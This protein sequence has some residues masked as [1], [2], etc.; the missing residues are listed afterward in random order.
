MARVAVPEKCRLITYHIHRHCFSASV[1]EHTLEQIVL[2]ILSAQGSRC[3][4]SSISLPVN[5]SRF[6]LLLQGM[7]LESLQYG[8]RRARP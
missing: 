3:L 5:A 7:M 8:P 4:S 2:P 6:P 1:I